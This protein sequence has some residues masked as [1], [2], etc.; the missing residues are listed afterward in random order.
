MPIRLVPQER[1]FFDLFRRDIAA[2]KA[3]AEALNTMLHD[4]RD[5]KR[6]ADRIH[7]IEHDG[8]RV[9]SEIFVLLNRT[10][11]TPFERED[12]IA[13]GHIIDGVL[14]QIDEVAI[15]LILYGVTQP[16]VYLLE[17][18]TLLDRAVD[19]LSAAISR[20]ESFKGLGPHVAEV[21]RLE[22]EADELYHNAIAE[23]FLP[24]AYPTLEVIKWNRIY[25][26]M[27]RAFDKCEDVGNVLENVVLKNG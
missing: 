13:L 8:D 15:M 9:T 1:A 25:D 20:L 12:I 22:N 3:A 16:T 14:D 11:V 26:I 5:L 27:E 7:E 2:C 21:H 10:F 19:E 4:Y 17:A 6:H 18:S 23:L 24:D